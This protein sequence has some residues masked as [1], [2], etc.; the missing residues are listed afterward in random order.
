MNNDD[1]A[2]KTVQNNGDAGSHIQWKTIVVQKDGRELKA[3]YW[4]KDFMVLCDWK[5]YSLNFG[6]HMMYMA[7]IKYTEEKIRR[8][9]E[10]S[11]AVFD[12]AIAIIEERKDFFDTIYKQIAEEEKEARENNEQIC[13]QIRELKKQLK[14][15]SIENKEYSKKVHALKQEKQ[16]LFSLR[17]NYAFG[18]SESLGIEDCDVQQV[19]RNYLEFKFSEMS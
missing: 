9:C 16:H 18:V 2:G 7:P 14:A 3:R 8:T 6:Y 5:G 10:N 12:K 17:S 13:A 1:K 15:G 4:A 19:I 11:F